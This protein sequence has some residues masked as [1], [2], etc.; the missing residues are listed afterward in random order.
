MKRSPEPALPTS[1]RRF[2]AA[3]LALVATLAWTSAEFTVVTG[4]ALA[5]E[6]GKEDKPRPRPRTTERR[7]QAVGEWAGKRLQKAHE[8]M[9]EDRTDDAFAAL[10]E[11]RGRKSLNAA[12]RAILWQT[13]GYLYATQGDEE[14]AAEA[15]RTCLA[16]N[17]LA[18]TAQ[19][20]TRRNLAQI[21]LM[22]GDLDAAIASFEQW[23][24][25]APEPDAD[26]HY[27]IALAY[28]QAEK[29][30]EAR[31][32]AEAAVAMSEVPKESRLQLLSAVYFQLELYD[33]LADV[34]TQLVTNFPRKSYWMQLSAIY[35]E[36]GKYKE[37]LGV[38]ESL[39]EQDLIDQS[40]EYLT[41]SRLYL[42][43]GVPWESAKVLEAGRAREQVE[44]NEEYWDL[45]GSSYLQARE[46]D[47]ALGPLEEAAKLAAD[48]RAWVRLGEVL[49]GE[50]KLA[51]SRR[52]LEAGIAKGGL[53][54]NEGRAWL[55]L[56]IANAADKRFDE[57][58]R[59]FTRAKTHP[60]MTDVA[61]QWLTHIDQE[62]QATARTSAESAAAPV[63]PS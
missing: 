63:E 19:L 2:G 49:L 31:P 62:E 9:S 25:E 60:E 24:A 23:L 36:Q 57:A 28:A 3:L 18:E 34:L 38:Q 43:A 61:A 45:L 5:A 58:R 51:A 50:E 11:L 55:L 37:A 41:L 59:A 33:Q 13:Y 47:A 8:A 26:A 40:R 52:A 7:T 12:E 35:I 6:S 39:F 42:Q 10:E 1:G 32:H 48:G 20:A 30:A 14:K 56:G 17:G 54:A 29:H 53:A 21:E 4:T 22:L 46:S 27:M 44:L 15:F 16:Q